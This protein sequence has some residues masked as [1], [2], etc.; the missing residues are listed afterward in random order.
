MVSKEAG[1]ILK[2]KDLTIDIQ[3]MWNVKTKVMPVVTGRME[4]LKTIQTVPE[5]RTGMHDIKELNKTSILC[6]VH[7][8]REVLM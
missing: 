7:V 3:L 6:T 1:K 2:Q 8:L 5:Q 4:H